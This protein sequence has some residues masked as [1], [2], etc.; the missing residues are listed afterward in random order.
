M[1]DPR[2]LLQHPF[3][4]FVFGEKEREINANLGKICTANLAAASPSVL[5]SRR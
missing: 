1:D 5:A 2:S 3:R 4:L